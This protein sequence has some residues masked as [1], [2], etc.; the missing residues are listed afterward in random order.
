MNDTEMRE[1]EILP[2]NNKQT[3]S[4][5]PETIE[6]KIGGTTYIVNGIYQE[7][8]DDLID[9]LWRLIKNETK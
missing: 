2:E 3:S 7:N 5:L 9:K 8:G 1:A 4:I 6:R